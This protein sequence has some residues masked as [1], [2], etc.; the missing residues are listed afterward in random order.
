MSGVR[1]T[2][3]A[4]PAMLVVETSSLSDAVSSADEW[5]VMVSDMLCNVIAKKCHITSNA[6]SLESKN[7][8]HVRLR[9]YI[10]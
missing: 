7:R 4:I 6:M 5:D 2:R 3:S 1:P 10:R 9:S 8:C